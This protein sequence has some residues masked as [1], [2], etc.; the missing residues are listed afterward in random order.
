MTVVAH[1]PLPEE[2]GSNTPVTAIHV[3]KGTVVCKVTEAGVA[4]IAADDSVKISTS[5]FGAAA[6]KDI[7]I[8]AQKVRAGY[9]KRVL[10]TDVGS[11]DDKRNA[12]PLT[13]IILRL[14]KTC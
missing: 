3:G 14:T 6:V 13:Q 11:W 7:W 2:R 5:L 12:L 1:Q 8:I 9:G 10:N 4:H